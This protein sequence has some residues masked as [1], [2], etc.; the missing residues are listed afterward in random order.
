MPCND[1]SAASKPSVSAYNEGAGMCQQNGVCHVNKTSVLVALSATKV[2]KLGSWRRGLAKT[3][4]IFRAKL[5]AWLLPRPRLETMLRL[6][7]L[8]NTH[9]CPPAVEVCRPQRIRQ[10]ATPW[11][12]IEITYKLYDY[13]ETVG[14]TGQRLSSFLTPFRIHMQYRS[15]YRVRSWE[16]KQ[17][18]QWN[19][20][21][22]RP[23]H[24]G[25]SRI[26][27]P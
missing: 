8:K 23:R 2:T 4:K 13:I 10:A 11:L 15:I 27:N 9:P 14:K 20:E 21:R 12:G 19:H 22:Y 26:I 3:S 16:K 18:G 1:V 17:T 5:A 24:V 6:L 25:I 7:P